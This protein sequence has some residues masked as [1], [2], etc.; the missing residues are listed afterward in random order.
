MPTPA[1]LSAAACVPTVGTE[2]WVRELGYEHIT[3]WRQWKA[4]SSSGHWVRA[5]YFEQYRPNNFTFLTISGKDLGFCG[6]FAGTAECVL[7]GRRSCFQS[8]CWGTQV[9]TNFKAIPTPWSA[10]TSVSLLY[11]A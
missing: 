9:A 11:A 5:G 4:Y 8:L 10:P 7:D 2:R 3:S 1:P 6:W